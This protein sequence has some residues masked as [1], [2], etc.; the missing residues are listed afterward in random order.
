MSRSLKIIVITVAVIFAL[1]LS[2]MLIVPWQ[3][4]KQGSND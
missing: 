1:L 2:S 3:V 4:K